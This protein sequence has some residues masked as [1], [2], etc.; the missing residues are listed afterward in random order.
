M[1]WRSRLTF[2]PSWQRRAATG[3][4]NLNLELLTL[5]TDTNGAPTDNDLNVNK[6][7]RR[8][9]SGGTH[10]TD[11]GVL[12]SRQQRTIHLISCRKR[13]KD[14]EGKK[15]PR[16]SKVDSATNF[17]P[18]TPSATSFR[19]SPSER[20]VPEHDGLRSRYFLDGYRPD[21]EPWLWVVNT[22][23]VAFLWFQQN[24]A[25]YHDVTGR[26]RVCVSACV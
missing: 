20:T 14:D 10:F 16:S 17:G 7:L 15:S 26:E 1:L 4:V 6:R 23:C 24:A 9:A 13:A 21:T 3:V 2:A 18:I 5:T 25:Q 11:T 12:L 19:S 8:S 22:N